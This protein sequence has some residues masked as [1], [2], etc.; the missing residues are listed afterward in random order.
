MGIFRYNQ[1]RFVGGYFEADGATLVPTHD[2]TSDSKKVAADL[3]VQ[4]SI[5]LKNELD[6]E[7]GVGTNITTVGSGNTLTVNLDAT[8]AGLTVLSTALTD[9]TATLTGGALDGATTGAFLVMLQ[10]VVT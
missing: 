10:L 9:G 3:K 8:L 5:A 2:I 7:T 4:D 6:S 1:S